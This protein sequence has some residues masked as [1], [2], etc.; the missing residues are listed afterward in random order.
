MKVL[1]IEDELHSA[2]LLRHE[3]K[4][5]GTDMDIVAE[6]GSVSD[7]VAWFQSHQSPDII[8]MDIK[9]TDGYSF[10]I[11]DRVS[12][13][14]PVIFTTAYDEFVMKAFEYNGIAYILKP[15]DAAKLKTAINRLKQLENHFIK[16]KIHQLVDQLHAPKKQRIVI[17]KG[18]DFQTILLSDIACFYVENKIVF[19]M[20]KT[21]KKFITEW[22]N[23]GDAYSV[24]DPAVFFRANRKYIIHADYIK[25][26]KHVDFGKT[27]VQL[28]IPAP[29]TIIVSQENSPLFRNWVRGQQVKGY[30]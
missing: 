30:Q 4:T 25:S 7:A 26:F 3:L 19:C 24:L 2:S 21:E 29:E 16:N 6:L 27:A 23:L 28:S 9:L 18:T 13:N 15:V 8:F 22:T 12:I 20:D 11:F 17:R 14:I 10:E 5:A 1:I